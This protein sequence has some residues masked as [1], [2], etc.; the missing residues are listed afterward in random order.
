M[1]K[2]EILRRN[3][4]R[5]EDAS[6]PDVVHD[7]A[8]AGAQASAGTHTLERA[9]QLLKV[10][11]GSAKPLTHAELVRRTGYSKASVSRLTATLVALGYLDRAPDGVR[12]QIGVR[13]LRLG[14]KYLANSPV[15][16]IAR[17]IMQDF[18]DRY[19]MSVGL[20][21]ADQLDMV[22]LQYCN[23]SKIATLR[24]GVGRTVPMALSSIGRAYVWAQPPQQRQRLLFSIW[25]KSGEHGPQVVAKMERAFGDLD[26]HGYCLAAGEYQRDT[27]AISVPLAL[28][29]PPLMMGLNCSAVGP[30]PDRLMIRDELAPALM[31]TA[32]LLQLELDAIDSSLF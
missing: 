11:H 23:S 10:F 12:V 13:G 22:Y 20:A 2:L 5:A 4:A 32:R 14:H 25:K 29:A 8:A 24:L 28:G 19:D 7:D 3:N 26:T 18:A 15:P 1:R 21:V 9:L 27:F 16:D 30:L 31:K 6:L 17:P